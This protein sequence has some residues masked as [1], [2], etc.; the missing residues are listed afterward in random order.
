MKF[1]AGWLIWSEQG[2][3]VTRPEILTKIKL[4]G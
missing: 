3:G 2:Q 4:L 1:K